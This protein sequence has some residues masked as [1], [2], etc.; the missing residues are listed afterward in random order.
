MVF[1]LEEAMMKLKTS[2]VRMT[3]Q[4]T[5]IL[6]YLMNTRNH[7]SADEIFRSIEK[8]F[9]HMSVATVYNNLKVFIA[10]GLIRE[11]TYGD[12]SSRFDADLSDHCHAV[13][14]NCGDI[15]DFSYKPLTDLEE[16]ASRQTHFLVKS[17]RL[18][19]YGLCFECTSQVVH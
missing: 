19:V 4:R 14:E 9:P 17:H 12:G 7:P 13:C 2:G 3:P 11:L 10:A 18:E 1:Y 5:A 8:K 15:K 6:A 16:I